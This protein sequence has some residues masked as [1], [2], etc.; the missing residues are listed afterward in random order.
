MKPVTK[1]LLIVVVALILLGF[2]AVFYLPNSA[3]GL[4][5]TP[6]T[7]WTVVSYVPGQLVAM[8]EDDAR[9]MVSQP[10][11]IDKASISFKGRSCENITFR[12]ENTAAADYL[13]ETWHATPDMLGIKAAEVQVV[14]TGCDIPGFKE[15]IR[16]DTGQLVIGLDGYFFILDPQK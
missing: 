16:L 9:A 5:A 8:S 1:T 13:L 15:Y 3:G 14:K 7:R 12:E 4:F 6:T 10:V 2:A 11:T